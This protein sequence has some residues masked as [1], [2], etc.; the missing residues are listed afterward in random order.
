MR[1]H[2]HI[3]VIIRRYSASVVEVYRHGVLVWKVGEPSGESINQED[4]PRS[5]RGDMASEFPKHT[6]QRNGDR[7]RMES[8]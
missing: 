6:S 3:T 5:Y 1:I 4:K 7:N 2:E 8:V